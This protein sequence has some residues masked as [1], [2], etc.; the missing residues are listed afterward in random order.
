MTHA[1]CTWSNHW[2]NH[3]AWLLLPIAPRTIDLPLKLDNDR[4]SL[5]HFCSYNAIESELH[6]MLECPLYNF[7][8]NKFPS[9]LENV[10]LGSLKS[11]FQLDLQVNISL[12]L[13]VANSLRHSRQLTLDN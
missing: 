7:I 10:I 2:H 13:T 5:F 4:L 1:I 11:F 8:S 6:I 12:Y 3:H 9:I